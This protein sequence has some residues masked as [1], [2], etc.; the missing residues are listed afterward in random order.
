MLNKLVVLTVKLEEHQVML[1]GAVN[2]MPVLLDVTR[3]AVSIPLS[4]EYKRILSLS[5]S[6]LRTNSSTRTSSSAL[7]L[8]KFSLSICND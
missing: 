6:L 5:S 2:V 8:D 7:S 3:S 1:L 4:P